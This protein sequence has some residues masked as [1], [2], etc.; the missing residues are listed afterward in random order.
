MLTEVLMIWV[1]DRADQFL[2]YLEWA[3]LQSF[4]WDGMWSL[5]ESLWPGCKCSHPSWSS[6]GPIPYMHV[7]NIIKSAAFLSTPPTPV[8]RTTPPVQWKRSAPTLSAFSPSTEERRFT[9]NTWSPC[10]STTSSSSSGVPTLSLVWDRWLWPGPLPRITGPLLSQMTFLPF[11]CFLPLGDLSGLFC[12]CGVF[13]Y[14]CF[15][16]LVYEQHK[17][18]STPFVSCFRYHTG[19]LAFG[20]LILSIVQIIRVLLE[21]LDHKL[22]G[23]LL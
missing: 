10:S 3:R 12:V 11:Q 19:S 14:C 21:Y 17:T 16:L 7:Y 20:S 4:Q 6:L 22:K 1:L 9:T 13:H 8:L 2:V 18:V 15:S 23:L 5:E